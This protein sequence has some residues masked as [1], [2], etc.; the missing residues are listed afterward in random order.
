MAHDAGCTT[1]V[2]ITLKG[3]VTLTDLIDLIDVDNAV[4]GR[5]HIEVGRLHTQADNSTSALSAAKL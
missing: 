1:L 2:R 3:Y 5:L 4:L